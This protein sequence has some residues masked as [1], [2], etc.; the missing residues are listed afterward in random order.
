MTFR[1][2]LHSTIVSIM[3]G[4]VVVFSGYAIL[5][6]LVSLL[7][8]AIHLSPMY[9]D[10]ITA[11]SGAL[12]A[13][14]SYVIFAKTFEKRIITELAPRRFGA[15]ATGGIATGFGL[16]SVTILILYLTGHYKVLSVNPVIDLLPALAIGI[17]SAVFEELM[18]RGI[19]FR[20]TEQRMGSVWALVFSSALFGFAHL[21]NAN[22]TV[23][24]SLSITIEA[25]LLLG[26]AYLLTRNLWFCIFIHFAW[27]FTEGGIF[28]AIIS[29]NEISASLLTP[30]ITGPDWLTGGGFGP[31]NSAI[32]VLLGLVTG[33]IF[34]L[35]A[36]K[37]NNIQPLPAAQNDIQDGTTEHSLDDRQ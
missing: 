25:G 37:K 14:G 13:W 4:L 26:A 29:G 19:I 20:I 9:R 33:I 17:S 6:Y 3:L 8:S 1:R 2:F 12:G 32:T 7:L 15:N 31:E 36:K 10:L 18:F 16:L 27:N 22:G 24:S 11:V 5:V 28:G 23:M 30:K 21:M 34:L 35:I